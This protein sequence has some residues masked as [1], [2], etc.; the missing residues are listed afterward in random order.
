MSRTKRFLFTAA[1]ALSLLA[2]ACGGVNVKLVNSAQKKPNNVWV[3]FTVDRGKNDP[4]GGLLAED[5]VIY[6]DGDLI[7][8]F[9]SKQ[10][11]QNPE[12]AAVMFTMLLVVLSG[13]ITDSGS[14]D[15]LVDASKAF[16]EKLG[17][18]Q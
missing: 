2:S 5:F 4:V 7:S 17:K 6:E 3:F 12:V 15:T 10:V 16:A 18:R 8:K 13:R 11:I 1:A 14:A 9:E